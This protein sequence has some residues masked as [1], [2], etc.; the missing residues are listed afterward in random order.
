[1]EKVVKTRKGVRADTPEERSKDKLKEMVATELTSF[2][3]Q[4]LNLAEVSV[5]GRDRYS[6]L[7]AKILTL[8]N[9]AKRAIE[10]NLDMYYK[11]EYVPNK[12]TIIEVKRFE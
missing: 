2:W 11:V 1:M 7:R 9:N 5:D 12:E 8:G 6:A 3:T 4:V 10:H